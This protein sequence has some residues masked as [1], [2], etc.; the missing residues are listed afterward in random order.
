MLERKRNE[1]IAQNGMEFGYLPISGRQE[2]TQES[3]AV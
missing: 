2:Q 3:I 1:A